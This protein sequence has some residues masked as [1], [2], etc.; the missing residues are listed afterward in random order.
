M[1]RLIGVDDAFM[2]PRRTGLRGRVTVP[3]GVVCE[4]GRQGR[5][6]VRATAHS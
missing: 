2:A 4:G 6:G 3:V 5:A 1:R